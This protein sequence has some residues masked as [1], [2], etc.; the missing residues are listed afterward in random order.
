MGSVTTRRPS[1]SDALTTCSR[2]RRE[3][4]GHDLAL[5]AARG[6]AQAEAEHAV[7]AD[8]KRPGAG[9]AQHELVAVARR[10]VTQPS[11]PVC[12]STWRADSIC[13]T[14]LTGTIGSGPTKRSSRASTV[15]RSAGRG[16]AER[17]QLPVVIH[18]HDL[19]DRDLGLERVER[20][21]EQER[22]SF[23]CE[24]SG[25]Q[26]RATVAVL[27]RSGEVGLVVELADLRDDE[28]DRQQHQH[29][30]APRAAPEQALGGERDQRQEERDREVRVPGGRRVRPDEVAA[31]VSGARRGRR[32]RRSRAPPEP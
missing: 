7:A 9:D 13:A 20:S 12:R 17:W 15:R 23:A 19:V 10:A 25:G 32:R 1:V 11:A 8:A 21:V 16:I 4:R 5:R 18:L 14:R 27:A 24:R 2:S 6:V 29:D 30:P 31:P 3:H 26:H 22:P 28:H